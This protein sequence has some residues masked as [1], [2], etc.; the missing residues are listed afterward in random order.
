MPVSGGP[1]PFPAILKGGCASQSFRSRRPKLS[2]ANASDGVDRDK[3]TIWSWDASLRIP[4]RC[5]DLTTSARSL[6]R[7]RASSLTKR[8]YFA[9]AL[10]SVARW[11]SAT[12]KCVT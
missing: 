11:I 7:G 3:R 10:G 6:A 9:S 12:G 2:T 8:F 4:S 5:K 1:L